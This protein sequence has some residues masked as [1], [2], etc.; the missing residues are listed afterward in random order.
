MKMHSYREINA[1][2]FN[3][4]HKKS[5]ELLARIATSIMLDEI[6][7]CGNILDYVS[8]NG[9]FQ[10]IRGFTYVGGNGMI[11]VGTNLSPIRHSSKF[12]FNSGT[13]DI[14]LGE[15][16][17]VK[18]QVHKGLNG[19]TTSVSKCHIRYVTEERNII[20]DILSLYMGSSSIQRDSELYKAYLDYTSMVEEMSVILGF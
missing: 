11:K 5:N 3:E 14:S 12:S 9:N 19:C 15:H 10:Y 1:N 16:R 8:G 18:I 13:L 7:R 2:R 17:F 4:L 6:D 20:R